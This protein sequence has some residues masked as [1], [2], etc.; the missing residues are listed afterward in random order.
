[1]RVGVFLAVIPFAVFAERANAQAAPAASP[2]C[3]QPGYRALDFWVGQW[4]TSNARGQKGAD[5]NVERVA[6]SCA[7]LERFGGA[8]G[9]LVGAGLHTYD[10]AAN[11]WTQYWTD[12]RGVTLAMTGTVSGAVV[13]YEWTAVVAGSPQKQRYTLAPQPDGSVVQTGFSTTDDGKTWSPTWRLTYHK[14]VLPAR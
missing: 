7:I 6:G 8:A 9:A 1:M 10:P 11:V 12:N 3:A 14:A 5:S 13:T 4:G 2:A